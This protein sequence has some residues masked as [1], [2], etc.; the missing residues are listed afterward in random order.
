MDPQDNQQAS[1][2]Q[3]YPELHTQLSGPA[4]TPVLLATCWQ[5]STQDP[6]LQR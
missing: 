3:L 6:L 2:L 4:F 1:F 5:F